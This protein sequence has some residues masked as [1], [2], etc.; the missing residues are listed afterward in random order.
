[1]RLHPSI[2]GVQC[3]LIA[4]ATH[5]A[6]VLSLK[7]GLFSQEAAQVNR[8]NNGHTAPVTA[9][10]NKASLLES[11]IN[12]VHGRPTLFHAEFVA[13]SGTRFSDE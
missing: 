5:E 6:F 3:R 9:F 2:V 11:T 10:L 4:R 7:S 13:E 1:M 8:S 12:D